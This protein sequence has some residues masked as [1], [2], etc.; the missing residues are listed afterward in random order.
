ME[1]TKFLSAIPEDAVTCQV[2]LLGGQS[3]LL[4]E[5]ATTIAGVGYLQGPTGSETQPPAGSTLIAG[6]ADTEETDG[7]Q[8]G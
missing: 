4:L 7:I 1:V 8:V 5:I 3:D 2:S 6:A